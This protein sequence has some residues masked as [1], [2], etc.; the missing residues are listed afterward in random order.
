MDKY[1]EDYEDWLEYVNCFSAAVNQ[2]RTIK[3]G[4]EGETACSASAASETSQCNILLCAP[5]PD[6]ETLTG[7]LS[8]RLR[9]EAHLAVCV[10]AI[11]LGSDPARKEARK[12][13]LSA[14]CN[15]LDFDLLLSCEPLAFD[16]V[17]AFTRG[18]DPAGWQ[19][20]V[21]TVTYHLVSRN[22]EMVIF[23]HDRDMHP[24]HLGTHFLMLAALQNYSKEKAKD[25]ILVETEF[26]HPLEKPNLLAGIQPED[27]ALLTTALARHQGE[28]ARNPYHLRLPARLMDN[29]RRGGELIVGH[30]R[31][32]PDI[33]F[34]ELYRVSL[35][36]N[37]ILHR[38]DQ[39]L[40]IGPEE[41]MSL[42]LI[43]TSFA[44]V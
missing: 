41:K 3:A 36:K 10:L 33:L 12:K 16:G 4:K 29:V 26:W 11:T 23:P 21:E 15:I 24:T 40:V 25:V 37:G 28:I 34:G 22:P 18:Q 6:D 20:M 43:Q 1:P 32:T 38:P 7:T 8:L 2:G 31:E 27:V 35:L 39:S 19:R 44:G 14:A 13:E 42:P 30:R 9:R 5:H 17:T